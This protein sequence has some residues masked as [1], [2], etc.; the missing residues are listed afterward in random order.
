MRHFSS[1]ARV[2]TID[3]CP[4]CAGVWLDSGEIERIQPG[5]MSDDARRQAV[6]ELFEEGAIDERMAL[7]RR[8]IE[9][10]LPYDNSRS[11]IVSSIVVAFYIVAISKFKM[12]WPVPLLIFAFRILSRSYSSKAGFSMVL[13][14]CV[15]PFVC[16]W[17]PEELGELADGRFKKSPRSFVWFLGWLVLMLP[18]IVAAILFAEGV[19]QSGF[20]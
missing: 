19:R 2:V 7:I 20:D 4:T 16:V 18:I 12:V 11:R 14:F 10:E 6:R 8:Q 1:P 17:F 15:L 13:A 5:Q 9:E 3:E